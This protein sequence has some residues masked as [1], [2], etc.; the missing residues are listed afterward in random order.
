LARAITP[1][2]YG[3]YTVAGS[4]T[5]LL[6]LG[7][8]TTVIDEPVSLEVPKSTLTLVSLPKVRIAEGVF[9]NSKCDDNNIT[10]TVYGYF[11]PA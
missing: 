8:P 11:V 9:L 10:V 2:A 6:E 3:E 5:G 4:A 7:T 1:L